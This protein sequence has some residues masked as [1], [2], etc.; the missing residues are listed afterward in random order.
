[1]G[2][3][4][5]YV[6][7]LIDLADHLTIFPTYILSSSKALNLYFRMKELED[8]LCELKDFI[9]EF[10]LEE[11]FKS[12]LNTASFLLKIYWGLTF[13]TTFTGGFVPFFTNRMA[14]KMYFPY[15]LEVPAFY[16]MTAIYQWI[17]TIAVSG[18]TVMMDML[19]VLFMGYIIAL[20]EQL[21]VKISNLKKHKV[22]NADGTINNKRKIDNK[23][24]LLKY[25]I[26]KGKY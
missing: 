18:S 22:L 8:L 23:K 25:I 21:S 6:E 24:E 16:Y 19:P 9:E 3:Y 14:Y 4:T 1:M 10:K 12:S 13:L 26:T 2:I 5:L 15:S 20:L 7:D 17:G 11:K